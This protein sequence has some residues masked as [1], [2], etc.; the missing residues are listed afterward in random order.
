MPRKG[1]SYYIG[2]Q[3]PDD[4]AIQTGVKWLYQKAQAIGKPAL[5]AVSTKGILENIQWATYATLFIALK[6]NDEAVVASVQ[7]KLMTLRSK[8]WRWDGPALVIY[9]GQGLL[10]AVDALEGNIDVL[11]IPWTGNDGD[12]WIATWNA[13]KLGGQGEGE[14]RNADVLPRVAEEA[15]A[16]LTRIVN[17]W[18]GIGHPGDYDQAVRT[19]ETLI[20]KGALADAELVRQDLIRRGWQPAHAQKVSDLASKLLD[21][22]RPRGSTGAADERLWALWQEKAEGSE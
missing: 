11:Y 5:I 14:A 9:G 21:G 15:L 22:R 16:R 7:F 20:R 18:T 4:G 19:I 3:G 17:L 1:K 2:S 10:D 12:G 8:V 6:R 13:Q